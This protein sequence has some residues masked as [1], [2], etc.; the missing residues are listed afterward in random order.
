MKDG[1]KAVGIHRPVTSRE[2][3]AL[4]ENVA[5]SLSTC[6][7]KD[8]TRDWSAGTKGMHHYAEVFYVLE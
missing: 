7:G 3:Q 2:Q 6:G 8:S 1:P 4:G 5:L